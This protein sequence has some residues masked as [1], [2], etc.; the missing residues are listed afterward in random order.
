[1]THADVNALLSAALRDLPAMPQVVHQV[2]AEARHKEPNPVRLERLISHDPALATKLLKFANSAYYG[3]SR[4]VTSVGQAI[5]VLGLNQVRHIVLSL[6]TAGLMEPKT[7]RQRELFQA[8]WLRA[9]GTAAGSQWLACH[10]NLTGEELDLAATGG[11]LCEV[12]R[13]FLAQHLTE[14]W[15]ECYA[16]A[17]PSRALPAVEREY[18][19]VSAG[20]VAGA[21][22]ATWKFPV[23]LEQTLETHETA[24][25]TASATVVHLCKAFTTQALAEPVTLAIM[26]DCFETLKIDPQVTDDL[27]GVILEKVGQARG[28]ISLMAA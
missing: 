13:M 9:L 1:M 2:L 16:Q 6:A 7:P 5:L 3:L 8:F 26:P 24:P 12:G 27:Q 25:A 11:L 15:L 14:H 20:D 23:A 17:G 18:F 21:L 22:A 19:G 4:Q 28:L 10:A